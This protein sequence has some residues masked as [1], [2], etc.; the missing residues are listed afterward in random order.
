MNVVQRDSQIISRKKKKT[1]CLLSVVF[2]GGARREKIEHH[3]RLGEPRHSVEGLQCVRLVTLSA[4]WWPISICTQTPPR[5]TTG[6]CEA[7]RL[8]RVPH[9]VTIIRVCDT[10]S[11]CT[12]ILLKS[13]AES[14]AGSYSTYTAS[15][16]APRETQT[17]PPSPRPQSFA[18]FVRVHPH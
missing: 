5:V 8:H 16:N 7:Y 6:C 3:A 11:Y 2:W 18:V 13:D 17:T 14:N 12:Y 1:T 10:N 4:P 15:P 9:Q